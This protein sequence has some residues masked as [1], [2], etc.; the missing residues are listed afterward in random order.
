M[1]NATT[2]DVTNAVFDTRYIAYVFNQRGYRVNEIAARLDMSNNIV[3]AFLRGTVEPGDL[4]VATLVNMA[5]LLGIPLASM[6]THPV[7]A[8]EPATLPDNDR[9]DAAED[10]DQLVACIYDTGRA[11]PV[12]IT[13]IAA[14]FD[15]T[16]DRVYAAADEADQRLATAGLRAVT[17]HGELFIT[18]VRDHHQAHKALTARKVY[19]R[20]L[21]A[22]HY[23]AVHQLLTDS[24]VTVSNSARQRLRTL[25]GL[26]NIGVITDARRPALT[27]AASEAFL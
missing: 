2:P 5:N 3:E 15:W 6:F 18:P 4:R 14:A 1:T 23:K 17:S 27:H 7:T 21:S 24:E 13:D 19:E 25:G 16:T 10:A 9:T 12:L 26:V 22:S 20:G 11:T 8:P